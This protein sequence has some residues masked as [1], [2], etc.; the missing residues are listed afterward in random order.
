ML[1][2]NNKGN[3]RYLFYRVAGESKAVKFRPFESMTI[4]DLVST[5]QIN[6]NNHDQ[7][8]NDYNIR[9]GKN[10]MLDFTFEATATTLDSDAQAFLNAVGISN[11]STIYYSG[12]SQQRTGSQLCDY[13]NQLVLELKGQGTIN[14]TVNFWINKNLKIFHPII[15]GTAN[16]HKY[17]LKNPATYQINWQGGWTHT[18]TGA[19]PNGTNAYADLGIAPADLNPANVNFGRFNGKNGG[20]WE[21]GSTDAG[22]TKGWALASFLGGSNFYATTNGFATFG[23]NPS[24]VGAY[25]V[26]RLDSVTLRAYNQGIPTSSYTQT[27]A[28]GL[29]SNFYY[30]A[31]NNGGIAGFFSTTELQ[32]GHVLD[33]LTPTEA[34]IYF[35]IIYNYQFNLGRTRKLGIF[36]GDSTTVGSGASKF[37]NRWSSLVSNSK[38]WLELNHG[39]QGTTLERSAD[40]VDRISSPNMYDIRNTVPNYI[41]GVTAALFYS[42]SINDC[43]LN[44]PSYN[45]TVFS[46]QLSE[47][48]DAATAK[49]WPL[50]KIILVIGFYCTEANWSDYITYGIGTAA[51][52]ARHNSFI[53]AAGAVA[54]NKGV[55][56][57]NPNA[58]MVAA[59]GTGP[60]GRHP[61]DAI[62]A[63]IANIS[64]LPVITAL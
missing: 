47:I 45:T 13:I 35:N 55:R 52:N 22:V 15:G 41:E 33:G 36:Y 58:D 9:F 18:A 64:V 10:F 43:G 62:N 50:A 42:Y 2:T 37:A 32:E 12:T 14:R 30:G 5:S 28:T 3:V 25:W 48:I 60:D 39:V 59:G 1:V 21:M 31:L 61:N 34:E 46:T 40:N 20:G 29:T 44:F 8:L 57:I 16:S 63:V 6:Y 24:Q 11:D 27:P 19:L 54:S 4:A 17:N 51:T 56:W 23:S 7:A 53:A 26:N 38:N 49:G